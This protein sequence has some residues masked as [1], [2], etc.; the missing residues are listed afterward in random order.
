MLIDPVCS[1]KILYWEVF[2][3]LV[4]KVSYTINVSNEIGESVV[5]VSYVTAYVF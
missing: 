4:A 5:T 1:E 2:A 3:L